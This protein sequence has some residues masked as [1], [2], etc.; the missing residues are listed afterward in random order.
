MLVSAYL[1]EAKVLW[2]G[3]GNFIDDSTTLAGVPEGFLISDA[4]D[5]EAGMSLARPGGR[6]WEVAGPGDGE[7]RNSG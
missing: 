5:V 7:Q 4:G 3:P 2:Q 6:Q 1:T